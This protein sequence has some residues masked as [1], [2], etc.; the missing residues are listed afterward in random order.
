MNSAGTAMITKGTAIGIMMAAV[1]F[2]TLSGVG[3]ATLVT[4]WR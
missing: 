4:M 2:A 3:L 1:V